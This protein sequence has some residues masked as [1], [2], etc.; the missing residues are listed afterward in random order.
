MQ[1]AAAATATDTR[2]LT[3][4]SSP[5]SPIIN[6]SED[7][8]S[9][10]LHFIELMGNMRSVDATDDGIVWAGGD[11]GRL[12]RSEDN[13]K[14]WTTFTPCTDRVAEKLDYRAVKIVEKNVICAMAAGLS[15]DD[16]ARV[17]RTED[18]GKTWS[19]VLHM[20]EDHYFFNGMKFWDKDNGIILGDP[21]DGFFVIFIT[22]DGGRNWTQVHTPSL[23]AFNDEAIFAASNTCL[24]LHGTQ[25]VWFCTG[26]GDNARVFF[27]SNGGRNWTPTIT[28]M[29]VQT[30]SSSGLFSIAFKSRD[31]G[32]AVGGDYQHK[33]DYRSSTIFITHD[34]GNTWDK[35]P[36]EYYTPHL[37]G[38]YLPCVAWTK[39]GKAV[40]IDGSKADY[41][42]LTFSGNTGWAVGF[43]GCV[44]RLTLGKP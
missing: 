19:L 2:I 1:P 40:V 12:A 8:I 18:N 17:Y 41:N 33:S 22:R 36:N 31:E 20:L 32:I 43:K 30:F 24:A 11:I 26:R 16:R 9:K 15:Q 42:A 25:D 39:D 28:P 6:F 29:K 3:H 23:A 14:S 35:A 37:M 5:A 44:A 27:S 10:E 34:G 38:K 21:V 7:H 4:K 13:G